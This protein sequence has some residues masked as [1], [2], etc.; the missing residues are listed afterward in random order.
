MCKQSLETAGLQKT[1]LYFQWENRSC[2]KKSTADQEC[3][4]VGTHQKMFGYC[5][6][7]EIALSN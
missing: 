1:E 7:G 6:L 4:G 3:T 5:F 2:A